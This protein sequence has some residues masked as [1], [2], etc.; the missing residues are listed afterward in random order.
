METEKIVYRLDRLETIK[1]KT[2]PSC[3]S[4]FI[5]EKECE[6]CGLQFQVDTLGEPYSDRS[7]YG[8]REKFLKEWPIAVRTGWLSLNPNSPEVQRYRRFLEHRL[9]ALMNYFFKAQ[10]GDREKKKLFFIELED[11]LAELRQV[12]S[13]L[14]MLLE[15]YDSYFRH[16]FY[17]TI[18]D[19]FLSAEMKPI[20]KTSF[21]SLWWERPMWGLIRPSFMMKCLFAVALIA[22]V[23]IVLFPYLAIRR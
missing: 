1:T 21:A 19:L 16:P 18:S 5:T 7:F 14:Q 3:S 13:N 9:D 22:Y 12:E 6:A 8:L 2:C 4:V 17:S 23:S 10:D 20:T 11:L 15:K